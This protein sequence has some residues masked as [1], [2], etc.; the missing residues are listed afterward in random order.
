[1]KIKAKAKP[2]SD[3][4]PEEQNKPTRRYGST[5]RKKHLIKDHGKL[6]K[7][8]DLE[9]E[10]TRM[11]G[12]KKKPILFVI[13]AVRLIKKGLQKHTEKVHGAININAPQNITLVG[14]AHKLSRFCLKRRIYQPCSARGPW[15]G[16]GLQD[17]TAD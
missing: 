8:K 2:D 15:S 5:I 11:C 10:T 17:Y 13:G 6:S 16:P 3:Q 9:I 14:T 4:R 12:M 1:M 7:Y